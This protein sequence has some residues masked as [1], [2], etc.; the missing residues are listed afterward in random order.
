MIEELIPKVLPMIKPTLVSASEHAR[1]LW[2][3]SVVSQGR[4]TLGADECVRTSLQRIKEHLLSMHPKFPM[5]A[6]K[7]LAQMVCTGPK[8]SERGCLRHVQ[9]AAGPDKPPRPKDVFSKALTA[10]VKAFAA[11][12]A[13]HIEACLLRPRNKKDTEEGLRDEGAAEAAAAAAVLCGPRAK[14]AAVNLYLAALR[15]V[16]ASKR[17]APLRAS[18]RLLTAAVLLGQSSV[19]LGTDSDLQY[20]LS[21]AHSGMVRLPTVFQVWTRYRFVWG[22]WLHTMCG[23]CCAPTGCPNAQQ[24]GVLPAMSFA[25]C[26]SASVFEDLHE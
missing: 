11:A 6:L 18:T 17:R 26:F 10:D 13:A 15:K 19:A 16:R 1:L 22:M 3:L 20:L 12:A 9:N 21:V 2:A 7:G 25:K 23:M 4:G 5:M 8:P 14:S 24:L